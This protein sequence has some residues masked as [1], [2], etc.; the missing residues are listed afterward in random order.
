MAGAPS[1]G[2]ETFFTRLALALAR[3]GADQ[4]LLLRLDPLRETK[5]A[6]AG[7]RVETA[8]FGGR[9][10]LRTGRIFRA[11]I[12]RYQ[13]DIVLTWMNRATSFCP[14]GRFVHVGTP[15]GYYDPKY[16]RACDHLVVTTEDLG[17][18]YRAAG[19]AAER[20]SVIP[21]FAP[22]E[23]APPVAR[24]SLATADDATVLLA[25][26]RLHANK[27]FDTLLNALPL[28]PE[29]H[30]LWL[31]GSGP[32]E[33]ELRALADRLGVAGRVR[34]LGWREDVPAL[35]AAADIFVCSSRHE[36]F[37]NIVIEAWLQRRPVVAIASEGPSA[38]IE[39]RRSGLLA[40]PE[41]AASLAATIARV[42]ADPALAASLVA[43]G[44]A[45]YERSY[46]E[47]SVVGAYVDLF[48]RLLR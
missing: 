17:R 37:G 47:E 6:A 5:L 20:V 32:L 14:R 34:F 36:P 24:A 38:L 9:L 2:A 41:D 19:F 3:R 35:F 22:D 11:A 48:N 28:L 40:P 44:R 7:A 1:G 16:Y 26:G 13:P 29:R 12:E 25:L 45:A 39:D 33:G 27:G 18:F 15:R 21:N 42:A 23:H 30:V 31:A 43:A 8:P 46:T 10:D 4:L